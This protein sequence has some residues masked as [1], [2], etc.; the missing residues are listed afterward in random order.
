MAE[1]SRYVIDASV[2][3]KWHLKDEEHAEIAARVFDDLQLG[4]IDL[5]APYHLKYEVGSSILK[6]SR[7]QR[8]TPSEALRSLEL[9]AYW[10]IHL[11]NGLHLEGFQVAQRLGCGYYDAIYLA[12]A[13]VSDMAFLSADDKLRVTVSNRFRHFL[14]IQDYKSPL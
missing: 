9:S 3:A 11:V 4:H 7:R 1:V 10:G 2:V 12:L 14:W 6:A 5:L 13:D 8:L